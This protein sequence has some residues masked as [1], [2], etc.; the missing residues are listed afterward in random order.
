MTNVEYLLLTDNQFTG[1]IPTEIDLLTNA[2]S[3]DLDFNQF[4][5][6][7]PTE[8]GLL[9]NVGYL[10]LVNDNVFTGSVATEIGLLTNGESL[11]GLSG[12]LL[13]GSFPIE[14]GLMAGIGHLFLSDNS[15][16]AHRVLFTARWRAG[17]CTSETQK[18]ATIHLHEATHE[19][20]VRGQ[21]NVS[22][23]SVWARVWADSRTVESCP[24]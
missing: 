16:T 9:A 12:N 21:A 23:S 3:L 17:V 6:S 1:S 5:G 20:S 15:F 11:L 14:I 19:L 4:T 13:S 10:L 22:V 8:I 24:R 2:E 7:L 18:S